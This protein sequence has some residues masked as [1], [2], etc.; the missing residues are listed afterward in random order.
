[1]KCEKCGEIL[2]KNVSVLGLFGGFQKADLYCKN[3]GIFWKKG[4]KEE[5]D[6][7]QL[8]KIRK[9]FN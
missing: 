6:F 9:E 3:D 5:E 1:M 4:S 7:K 8:V 2:E